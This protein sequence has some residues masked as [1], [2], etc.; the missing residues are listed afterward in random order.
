MQDA[1]QKTPLKDDPLLAGSS[2]PALDR[3]RNARAELA[4]LE[5]AERKGSTLNAEASE[6]ELAQRAL[7]SALEFHK[8]TSVVKEPSAE[9]IVQTA[10]QFLA[11]LRPTED[12]SSAEPSGD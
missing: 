10:Q 6:L 12:P 5:L 7:D 2:S 1:D 11:F 8:F 3:Y 9:Q 4:E